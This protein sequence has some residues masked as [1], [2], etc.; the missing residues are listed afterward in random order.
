MKKLLKNI[1][2]QL[3]DFEKG[4]IWIG[5]N[6]NEKLNSISEKDV[7]IRP[8]PNL[9]SI[10]EIISHLTVWRNETILKIK[11]GEGSITDDCEEN[12]LTN[13][14]LIEK[15]W[16]KIISE[17]KDSLSELIEILETKDD[18]FLNE[19]YFDTDFKDYF[20]Y[21]FVVYGMLHHDIY[22]LGQLGIIIKLL[23]EGINTNN[24]K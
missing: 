4:K 22:H 23:K 17:Y 7:F 14:K 20:E 12:W 18:S 5:T 16:N 13:D 3:K 2:K 10:S 1:I 8:F 11:T 6:Y 24:R 9:H 19:K 21:Q 15:G